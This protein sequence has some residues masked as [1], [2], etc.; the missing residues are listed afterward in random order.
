MYFPLIPFTTGK[1][2]K[3]IISF[4]LLLKRDDL[5]DSFLKV[6]NLIV[7]NYGLNSIYR[8]AFITT[9]K[10]K[11]IAHITASF[12]HCQ[13]LFAISNKFAS[14]LFFFNML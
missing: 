2:L 4:S 10:N 3:K 13:E 8:L 1:F 14:K 12:F 7:L 11:R 9:S 5:L 6:D